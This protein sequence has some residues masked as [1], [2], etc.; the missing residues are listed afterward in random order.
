MENSYDSNSVILIGRLESPFTCNLSE[1][2]ELVYSSIFITKRQS[3]VIDRFPVTISEKNFIK[4]DQAFYTRKLKAEGYIISYTQDGKLTFNVR[5][6]KLFPVAEEIPDYNM[7][8]LSGDICSKI[9]K[10]ERMNNVLV[11]DFL[12]ATRNRYNQKSYIPVIAW[13]ERAQHILKMTNGTRLIVE[14]RLQSRNFKVKSLGTLE[15]RE[16]YE[17]SVFKVK[18]VKP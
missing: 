10:R 5:I 4:D 13:N 9:R 6:T 1:A 11:C 17:V 16:A 7:V 18:R 14:G 12:L 15:D 8:K 3:G 2:G